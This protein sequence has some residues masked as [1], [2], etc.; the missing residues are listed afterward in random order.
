MDKPQSWTFLLSI[1]PILITKENRKA[2]LNQ[3]SPLY[4]ARQVDALAF[5]QKV[6]EP[7]LSVAKWSTVASQKEP[8]FPFKKQNE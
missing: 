2:R 6:F 8:N 4:F 5:G 1:M 7:P 3:D